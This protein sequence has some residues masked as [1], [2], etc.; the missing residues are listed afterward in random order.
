MRERRGKVA[1]RYEKYQK[2]GKCGAKVRI[3]AGLVKAVV[4]GF[5]RALW[6]VAP[7]ANTRFIIRYLKWSGMEVKGKP[8]YIAGSVY[9]DGTDHSLIE[10]NEGCTIAGGCAS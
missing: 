5:N 9:F 7:G 8:N 3:C 1:E 10:L 6:T 4:F 2:V